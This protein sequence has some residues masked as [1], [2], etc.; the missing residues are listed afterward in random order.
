MK[1]AL[2]PNP[3]I[4]VK[5]YYSKAISFQQGAIL[6]PTKYVAISAKLFFHF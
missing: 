3:Q 2:G 6:F 1:E 5:F 4:S